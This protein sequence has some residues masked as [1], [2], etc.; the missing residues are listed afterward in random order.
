MDIKLVI[1]FGLIALHAA[2]PTNN[3]EV[4]VENSMCTGNNLFY[5]NIRCEILKPF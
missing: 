1:L 2:N 3:Q 4:Q 5:L